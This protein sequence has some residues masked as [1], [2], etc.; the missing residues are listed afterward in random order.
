MFNYHSVANK[1]NALNKNNKNCSG[2]SMPVETTAK[3]HIVLWLFTCVN[4]T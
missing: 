4:Q 2:F 3:E 1:N